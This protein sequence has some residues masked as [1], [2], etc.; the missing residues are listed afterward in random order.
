METDA[1]TQHSIDYGLRRRLTVADSEVDIMTHALQA[2]LLV[3][4]YL[5]TSA[6]ASWTDFGI[7]SHQFRATLS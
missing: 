1:Q 7:L 6:F 2:H 4:P 3:V 5:L